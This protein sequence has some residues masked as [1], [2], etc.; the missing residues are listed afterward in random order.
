MPARILVVD[1]NRAFAAML[2]EMI[3]SEAGHEVH[4]AFSA[5]EALS[6]LRRADFDLAILDMDLGPTGPDCKTV[7]QQMRTVRPQMRLILIP[8]LGADL[9]AEAAQWDIQ[10][11]LSKPF[12]ADDLLPRIDDALAKTVRKKPEV[13]TEPKAEPKALPER[14][15]RA[16][17]GA[18]APGL[19]AVLADLARETA[20]D[21]VLLL[22]L[23]QGQVRVVEHVSAWQEEDRAQFAGL[24]RAIVESAQAA[25]RFLGYPDEAFEHHMF[26]GQDRRLYAMR[27]SA[28]WLLV[29][30]TPAHIPLGTVRHNLRR[31]RRDLAPRALT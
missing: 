20:A 25:A 23:V 24:V 16:A 1:R 22:S 7:V 4:V 29:V 17:S 18:Q 5:A 12:F 10:G 11:S 19:R 26:E 28:G 8:I 15:G 9:P 27:L 3:A 21:A 6:A 2:E 14:A 30:A 31:V 13:T